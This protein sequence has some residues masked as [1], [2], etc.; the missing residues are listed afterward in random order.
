MLMISKKVCEN[1]TCIS[2]KRNLYNFRFNPAAEAESEREGEVARLLEENVK[3]KERI[4]VLQRGENANITQEVEKRVEGCGGVKDVQ[5]SFFPPPP[6]FM[7][8]L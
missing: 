2:I 3:L 6:P 4:N 8:S 7:N 5:G 1:I